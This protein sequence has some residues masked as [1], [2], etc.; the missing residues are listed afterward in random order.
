MKPVKHAV[1]IAVVALAANACGGG[2][3]PAEEPQALAQAQADSAAQAAAARRAEEER[4]GNVIAQM[5][6]FDFDKSDIRADAQPIFERKLE[7]L[8]T[9][10]SYRIRIEGHCDERG[11]DAYNLGLGTRRA[12]AARQYLVNRGID[13]GRIETVSLGERRPIDNRSNREAWA[14]NRRVEFHIT[15]GPGA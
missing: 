9:N 7:V 3:E 4:Q 10:T 2:E 13:A 6:N 11:T 15:A 14:R 5:V 1:M 12:N 8:R